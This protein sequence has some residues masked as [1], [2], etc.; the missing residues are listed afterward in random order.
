VGFDRIHPNISNPCRDDE[1][2]IDADNY[3]AHTRRMAKQKVF[4]EI[5]SDNVIDE[6]ESDSTVPVIRYDITSFGAD[7]D[8]DGL[9]RRMKRK[10]I[11]APPF[12]RGY[13]W[14][15]KEG[16]RFIES[17]LLGLPVPGIFLAKESETNKFL[18]IDGQQRLKTLQFFFGGYFNPKDDDDKSQVFQLE[19]VQKPFAGST[20]EDLDEKDRLRLENSIIHATIIKQDSPKDENTSIY[21]IFERLNT[22]GLK[23]TAQ[24]VRTA[25]SYGELI[26]MLK[27]LNADTNWR[28]IFG[29]PSLRLKDQELILRFLAFYLE[30]QKYEKPVNEFLNG[31]VSRHRNPPKKFLDEAA[32]EFK[33]VIAISLQ[34]FGEKAFR[35]SGS[36]NAAVFDSVTVG[37]ARRLDKGKIKKPAMVAAAYSQLLQN[38][39]FINATTSATSDESNVTA[40]LNAATEAFADVE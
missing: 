36:L 5:I 26:L 35:P 28:R 2:G 30:S 12:Q 32:S 39:N 17:L 14:N 8:V 40:R 25:A 24:E 15:I 6:S 34:A 29:R 37:I 33:S 10:E 19:E 3:P 1:R 21:H 9:V 13:V 16:S 23:L 18:I 4:P 22:G 11:Y 38:E 7:Y 27:T 31:F 20:Y